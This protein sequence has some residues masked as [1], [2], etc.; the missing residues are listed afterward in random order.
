MSRVDQIESNT[1]K[2][3]TSMSPKRGHRAR[4]T[5]PNEY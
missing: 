5:S 4:I 1:Q 3:T 2:R